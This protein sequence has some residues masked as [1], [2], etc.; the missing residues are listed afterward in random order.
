[1]WNIFILLS[2]SR[3]RDEDSAVPAK[4]CIDVHDGFANDEALLRAF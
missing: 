1:M 3:G 4:L 2:R